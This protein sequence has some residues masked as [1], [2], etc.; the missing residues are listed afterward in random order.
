M[1]CQHSWPYTSPARGFVRSLRRSG[2]KEDGQG[3]RRE[4]AN[5]PWAWTKAAPGLDPPRAGIFSGRPV[6]GL[7]RGSPMHAPRRDRVVPSRVGRDFNARCRGHGAVAS[8]GPF[9]LGRRTSPPPHVCLLRAVQPLPS[10]PQASPLWTSVTRL[11][12]FPGVR[13]TRS[14]QM[15]KSHVGR[16]APLMR[17]SCT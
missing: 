12:S 5:T 16:P 11:R 14:F 13:V 8:S 6:N 2:R 1:S 3:R 17:V 4:L 15:V 7:Q 10:R 9:R